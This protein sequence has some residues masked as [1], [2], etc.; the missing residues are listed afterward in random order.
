MCCIIQSVF[1]IR[2]VTKQFSS[3][4]PETVSIH[5]LEVAECK[6]HW[7]TC[8]MCTMWYNHQVQ[9]DLKKEMFASHTQDKSG[10]M[11]ETVTVCCFIR[12]K[13]KKNVYSGTCLTDV[14]F[15]FSSQ[16]SFSLVLEALDYDN[17]TSESGKAAVCVFV[18]LSIYV[19]VHR[20]VK[21][22][23]AK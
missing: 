15:V 5:G 14:F 12:Y 22:R 16:K 9:K 20:N 7:Q 3:R 8:I 10:T 23:E 6:V 18:C 13:T 2:D 4:E 1:T 19:Q 17:D 11:D 21:E